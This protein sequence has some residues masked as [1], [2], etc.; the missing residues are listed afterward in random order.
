V[1]ETERMA[2]KI[3]CSKQLSIDMNLL[4]CDIIDGI[5]RCIRVP[6]DLQRAKKEGGGES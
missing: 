5:V 2:K 4:I 3:R 1:K 6:I